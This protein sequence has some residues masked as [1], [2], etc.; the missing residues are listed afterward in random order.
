MAKARGTELSDAELET[1]F[2][3]SERE[4]PLP[5][6]DLLT[7]IMA[8][9]AEGLVP[10]PA[11]P[12]REVRPCFAGLVEALGGAAGL[13]GL[14]AAVA[15]G[16]VIGIFPPEL[17]TSYTQALIGADVELSDYVPGLEPGLVDGA[18]DG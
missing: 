7:R 5:S 13:T 6:G 10:G 15:T 17:V 12:E 4:A 9:A 18:F 8:D 14:G 1:L 16:L 11:L 2:A 3:A